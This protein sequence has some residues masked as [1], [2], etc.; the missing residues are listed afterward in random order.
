MAKKKGSLLEEFKKFISRGNVMDMAV[1]II[2]GTAFT[3]IVSSLVKD[4]LMPFISLIIGGIN[5]TDLKI[6]IAQATANTAEVAITYGTFIQKVIDFLIIAFVVFMMIRTLNLL[7]TR[8]KKQEEQ[9]AA[10]EEKK[11]APPAP[12]IVLL[13]EIRDL[14]KNK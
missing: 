6:V 14:L 12:D 7:Q 4:I 11:P 13:T 9:Q 5:F 2:I 10:A 1:G 3:A 8:L